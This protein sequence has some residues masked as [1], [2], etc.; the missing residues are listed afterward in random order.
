MN[1]IHLVSL[2]LTFLV[3]SQ[4]SIYQKYYDEAYEIASAMTL[5]QKIGQTIQADFFAITNKNK[6]DPTLAQKYH[7]GSL[8]VGGNG[9]PT[10]TG[11]LEEFGPQ[12]TEEKI[13]EIYAN[14]TLDKWQALAAKFANVLEKVT[15]NSGKTYEISPLLA[16]DAV[17]NNQHVA[18]TILFPHNIGLSCSHNPANFFNAGKWTAQN[19]KASGFNY[20]FAPTV[21]VS[22]NPQWGRFYETMGQDEEMIYKYAQ[23]FTEG[24]QGKPG[25]LTGVLASV[26]HYLGDGATMYGADEGN[27]HVSSYKSFLYRNS[28]GYNG[29]I[30][31]EVGSVMCSY[32]AINYLPMAFS[33]LINSH[34][35][36]QL[37]FDGFVIGDYDELNKVIY[38]QLPS[39]F[40]TFFGL[41]ESISTI[42][43]A[44]TDMMMMP[45]RKDVE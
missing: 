44:G 21:A 8:L 5:D 17:H 24:V 40:Q 27:A 15:T 22:H 36:N 10:A 42:F 34:L 32:S 3:C 4:A 38:N 19:V 13:G 1:K 29:S 43:N 28:Q 9:C 35:R 39:G 16:T 20:A 25:A 41:N 23:A 31:A 7:L 14:A 18:G 33:P 26:K 12:T 6:T 30:A 2:L 11:D 37:K 45:A